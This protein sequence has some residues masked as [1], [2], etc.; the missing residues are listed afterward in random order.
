MRCFVAAFLPAGAR[1][2]LVARRPDVEGVRWVAPEKYHVTL[3]FLGELGPE[4]VGVWRV[5]AAGLDAHFPVDC[6]AR[7]VEGFPNGRRARV[8]V[9]RVDS[10]G[11][12]EELA[13]RL[14]DTGREDRRQF[15]A[16]VT[17]GRARRGPV[18]LRETGSLDLPF[19]LHEVG[20]Y[21]SLGGRYERL[22]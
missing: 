22:A 8:I 9:V 19:R 7:A 1:E 17:V 20:L 3:R 16:H 18:R 11:V 4:D 14:P 6:T 13:G 10:G 5:A 12:L 15:R 21:R 2:Q